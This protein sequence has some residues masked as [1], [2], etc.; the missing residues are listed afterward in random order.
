MVLV[1]RGLI[2]AGIVLGA[3]VRSIAV[4]LPAYQ[5]TTLKKLSD[6]RESSPM[7]S[8]ITWLQTLHWPAAGIEDTDSGALLGQEGGRGET[9][10]RVRVQA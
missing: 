7:A 1:V 3:Q 4:E 10:V 2:G 9:E 6:L 8:V 5:S